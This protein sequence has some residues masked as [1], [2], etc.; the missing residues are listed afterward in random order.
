MLE[1]PLAALDAIERLTGEHEANVCGY[2][3]GG[4]LLAAMMAWME[5]KGDERVCSAT[6]LTT[7]VDFSDVGD[8]ELFIDGR[9]LDTL[10]R[11]INDRGYLDGRSVGDTFSAMRANDLIWSFF[12]NSYLLG[13]SPRPFDILYWNADATNMP[14]AMHTYFM[15]NMYLENRLR[16]PGGIELAG[17][18]IDVTQVR[19]PAYIVATR[20]DHIAP[21]KTAYEST[22]LFAGPVKFVLG[23]SGHIAGVVNPPAKKK[24]G[25][26]TSSREGSRSRTSGSRAR[27][28][29]Q[30]LGGPTG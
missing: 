10:E 24:Y 11:G 2:C 1:G 9:T 8:I 22:Q 28:S 7:M 25:Y 17:V 26:W 18:P 30:A 27:R 29:M 16:E 3:L 6:Y 15:R 13:K 12:V 23:A 5:A 4:I 21:W 19:T 14:A 20:E